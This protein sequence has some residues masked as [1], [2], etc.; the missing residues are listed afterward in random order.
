VALLVAAGIAII[1]VAIENLGSA[2]A[3]TERASVLLE[4]VDAVERS[5]VDAETGLRG[6]VITADT[7]FL[8]PLDHA[9]LALPSEERALVHTAAADREF[10]AD[11]HGLVVAA[12]S[13]LLGYV[14]R[15]LAM[16]RRPGTARSLAVTLAGKT[17]VDSIRGRAARL[18]GLLD[19]QQ[20]ARAHTAKA[21]AARATAESWVLLGLLVLFVGGV[22]LILTRLLLARQHALE[23]SRWTAN[24]LQSSLLPIAVPRIPGCDLATRFLAAGDGQ[25]VGGDFYDVFR[26]P[27]S[28]RWAIVVGDVVGK[29]TEAA[30][31]TAM[32]RWTLRSLLAMELEPASALRELNAAM[33]RRGFSFLFATVAF[34]LVDVGR[35]TA[36]ATIACAG[37]PPPI[38]LPREGPVAAVPAHGSLVGA[39]PDVV[40]ETATV[41]LAPGDQIVAYTDGVTDFAP[42]AL[43]PLERLLARA[44]PS[45]PDATAALLER[46]A[47]DSQIRPRDDVAIVALRF[48]GEGGTAE[49]G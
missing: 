14:P 44:D 16:M 27:T 28:G 1:A 31:T 34:I 7:L 25:L 3:G 32:V 18:E 11:S 36:P 10:V 26:L 12:N 43:E 45:D 15:V 23:Q 38:V 21:T 22:G 19:R 9:K 41:S 6:F 33:L 4:R 40:F 46:R 47:L 42:A 39:Y 30:A 35:H 2:A 48:R 13:Y 17:L 5:V 29:G 24:V 49:R 20:S 37:H 8:Q